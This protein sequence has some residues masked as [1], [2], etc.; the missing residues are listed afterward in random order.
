MKNPFSIHPMRQSIT[1]PS[2]DLSIAAI[3]ASLNSSRSISFSPSPGGGNAAALFQFLP[4]PASPEDP[5]SPDPHPP[6]KRAEA[7]RAA[8]SS[9]PQRSERAREKRPEPRTP[10]NHGGRARP[11][12]PLHRKGPHVDQLSSGLPRLD[13]EAQPTRRADA[14]ITARFGSAH[15][16]APARRIIGA[17][18]RSGIPGCG[19]S[20]ARSWDP[21]IPCAATVFALTAS[22]YADRLQ[23]SFDRF[24]NRSSQK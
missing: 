23:K 22:P 9:P 24:F 6:Q 13:R 12:E 21:G 17:L 15:H 7:K 10:T 14:S 11:R 18:P 3:I 8:P 5:Q 19:R 16:A 2:P 4:R 20:P 1:G